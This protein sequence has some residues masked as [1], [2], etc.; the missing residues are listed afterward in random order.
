[1]IRLKIENNFEKIKVAWGNL[2]RKL[3]NPYPSL[4]WEWQET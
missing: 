1:M 2:W 4:S 3:A